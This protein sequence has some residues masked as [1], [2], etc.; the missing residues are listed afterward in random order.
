M[1]A[2][3]DLLATVQ[4]PHTGEMLPYPYPRGVDV[5]IR[6]HRRN[7]SSVPS[8]HSRQNSSWGGALRRGRLGRQTSL[9]SASQ[10]T[11]SSEPGSRQ[12]GGA[13]GVVPPAAA[14]TPWQPTNGRTLSV[15]RDSREQEAA[16]LDYA[17]KL[18]SEATHGW[19]SRSQNGYA[20]YTGAS[21]SSLPVKLPPDLLLHEALRRR[22]RH[23][24]KYYAVLAPLAMVLLVAGLLVAIGFNDW[25]LVDV[26]DNPW[27][28]VSRSALRKVG[29]MCTPCIAGDQEWWRLVTSLFI[30]PGVAQLLLNGLIFSA[31]AAIASRTGLPAW[32]F[33]ACTAA[34][35]V[36]G[37]LASALAAEKT[38][39]STSTAFPA[40]AAAAAI[41]SV[42]SVS[43]FLRAWKVIVLTLFAWLGLLMV[44][45]LA[46]FADTWASAGGIVGGALCAAAAMGPYL[47]RVRKLYTLKGGPSLTGS[48]T[49]LIVTSTTAI[50]LPQCMRAHVTHQSMYILQRLMRYHVMASHR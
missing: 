9:G 30:I 24:R 32:A 37:T 50:C 27:L 47:L 26:S 29:A 5:A 15:R 12:W 48:I 42:L 35:G 19:G 11:G 10:Q 6:E 1:R 13:N 45:S 20:N 43:R 16:D 40:A 41:V 8:S 28:G 34:G 21:V 14:H 38:I 17:H 36:V 2:Q 44:A 39:H 33:L 7:E 23:E 22:V 25:T 49:A 18:A 3:A 31:A 4:D 46:P